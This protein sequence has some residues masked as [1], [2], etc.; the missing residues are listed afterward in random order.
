VDLTT[1]VADN[2]NYRILKDN[3]LR[4][5]GGAETDHDFTA[6]D[7]EPPMNIPA[8]AE[9]YGA[10][11]ELVDDPDAIADAITESRDRDGPTVLDVA[12]HD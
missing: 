5:L 8:N 4:V 2:R 10:T 12:I 11:G 3:T 7:F 1:V 6:M 9:S